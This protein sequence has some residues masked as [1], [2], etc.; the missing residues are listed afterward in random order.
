[1]LISYVT[2]GFT[3]PAFGDAVSFALHELHVISARY[4]FCSNVFMLSLHKCFTM[5]Q[6][7]V[8]VLTLN[9]NGLKSRIKSKRDFFLAG[10]AF[11]EITP[12]CF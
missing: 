5:T 2:I 6:A 10:N 7:L 3:W 11:E 1:M 12:T 4:C 9:C 8:K